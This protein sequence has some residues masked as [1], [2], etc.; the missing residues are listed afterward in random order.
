M[1]IKKW[2]GNVANYFQTLKGTAG[3]KMNKQICT[4]LIIVRLK[5]PFRGLTTFTDNS[6]NSSNEHLSQNCHKYKRDECH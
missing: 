4:I 5:I 1:Y 2:Y 6:K 3:L